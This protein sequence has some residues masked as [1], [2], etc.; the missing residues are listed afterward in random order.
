MWIVKHWNLVSL[1]EKDQLWGYWA[2][3]ILNRPE[4][5]SEIWQMVTLAS[6]PLRVT[7]H[8]GLLQPTLLTVDTP[9][10]VFH[11]TFCRAPHT[12]TS[13]QHFCHSSKMA[14]PLHGGPSSALPCAV[15]PSSLFSLSPE[16]CGWLS[17]RARHQVG[18]KL[19][20]RD[21]NQ[22][23]I[24]PIRTRTLIDWW[25]LSGVWWSPGSSAVPLLFM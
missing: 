2:A 3:A 7:M 17:G 20:C 22:S 12:N 9:L 15:S 10:R 25:E 11:D 8:T 21:G 16:L 13:W 24:R 4:S 5:S 18:G 6:R 14:N 1:T 19:C 23:P